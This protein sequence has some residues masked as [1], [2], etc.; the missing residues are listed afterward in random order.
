MLFSGSGEW[1]LPKKLI[2]EKAQGHHLFGTGSVCGSN[3]GPKFVWR[4]LLPKV[5]AQPIYF[6]TSH[7]SMC[8]S[9]RN[10]GLYKTQR[11]PQTPKKTAYIIAYTAYIESLSNCKPYEKKGACWKATRDGVVLDSTKEMV[12]IYTAEKPGFIQM[13]N[14][15]NHRYELPSCRNRAK[16]E[17][18]CER[19][20]LS[21]Q[22][23]NVENQTHEAKYGIILL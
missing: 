16:V 23:R 9:G 11:N 18:E 2:P 4:P 17:C 3:H 15:F 1:A 12:S 13:L 20:K 14:S 7:S 19:L 22:P 6:S 21:D 10:V 5:E 8:P